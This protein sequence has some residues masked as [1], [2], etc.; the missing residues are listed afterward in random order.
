[1]VQ[2]GILPRLRCAQPRT[3]FCGCRYAVAGA[4]TS[5]QWKTDALPGAY[6]NPQ[7]QVLRSRL[8]NLCAT[9]QAVTTGSQVV[10]LPCD[11]R[12]QWA[13]DADGRLHLSQDSDKCM[14]TEQS[15]KFLGCCAP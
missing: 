9:P 1:M 6:F 13:L 3:Q 7:N 2:M 14:E 10:M 15:G 4:A 5:L 11:T 8:N 12:T